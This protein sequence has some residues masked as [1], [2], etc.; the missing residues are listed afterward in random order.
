[1]ELYRLLESYCRERRLPSDPD[2]ATPELGQN[3]SL[4]HACL[5]EAGMLNEQVLG[6]HQ[7]IDPPKAITTAHLSRFIIGYLPGYSYSTKSEDSTILFDLYL[8]LKW[9]EKRKISHG[10]EKLDFQKAV[11]DISTHR[12]RCRQLSDLIN[13]L[14]QDAL[15]DPPTIYDTWHDVFIVMRLFPDSMNIQ[16]QKRKEPVRIF[17]PTNLIKWIRKQD[18]M[19][20]TLGNTAE[21]WI[22]I[23]E[24]AIFPGYSI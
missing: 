17:L 16:G 2:S 5:I 9:L 21:G 6:C 11:Q 22:I 14:T 20:L 1:M 13:S 24:N 15:E 7:V 4:F 23:E 18:R 8:F 19:E 12:E 3:L 10:L